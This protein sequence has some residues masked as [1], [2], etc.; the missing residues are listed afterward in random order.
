MATAT[1]SLKAAGSAARRPAA[2]L[3]VSAGA[4]FAASRFALLTRFPPFWDESL[5]ASWALRVHESIGAR[6]VALGNGK[7]PLLSWLGAGGMAFGIGPLTAVRLVSLVAG[8]G[9]A[10]LAARL[11]VEADGAGAGV[12]AVVAYVVLPLAVVHDVMGLMEPLLGALFALAL[13]LQVRLA[14]RPS[15]LT[16]GLLGVT[17]FSGLLTKE[18]GY[19]PLALLPLSLLAFDWRPVDRMRRLLRWATAAGLALALAGCA[20]VLVYVSGEW[21]VYRQTQRSFGTVRSLHDG[22]AHPIRRFDAAWPG[23]RPELLGYVTWPLAIMVVVGAVASIV[24]RRPIGILCV[25][26]VAAL[27]AVDVLFLTN[28]FSRYLVPAGALVA[29]LVGIGA[30]EAVRLLH[31]LVGS[32]QVLWALSAV[33]AAGILLPAATLDA[34][35]LFHPS[36]APYPGVSLQEYETGWSA[37][38]GVDRLVSALRR[39]ARTRSIDVTWY[40]HL[41][42]AVPLD[43]RTD[44]L[45]SFVASDG[46]TAAAATHASFVVTNDLPLPSDPGVGALRP[47][48]TVDRPHDGVPLVLYQRGVAWAGRFYT[49]ANGLRSGLGLPDRRFDAFIA[50]HP[51]IRAW[52]LAVAAP[53][54]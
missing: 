9:S 51:R 21:S 54:S 24:R 32:R 12:A 31:R 23:Y 7:L 20:E 42:P 38:T 5:Y 36:T 28:A 48:L 49:T 29:V 18:T 52:Y 19:L 46:A 41:P 25:A 2:V 30:A 6:W 13:L 27:F 45:V 37:G 39:E 53:S 40:G 22:L 16:G 10:V 44:R 14:S 1:V 3:C 50:G 17:F 26:W 47:V 8:A 35:V 43:L 33:S 11:A 4:A 34:R 15:L